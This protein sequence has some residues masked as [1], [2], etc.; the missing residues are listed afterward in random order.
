MKLTRIIELIVKYKTGTK[1]T[2]IKDSVLTYDF[3][4]VTPQRYEILEVSIDL[5]TLHFIVIRPETEEY[6]FGYYKDLKEH[7]KFRSVFINKCTAARNRVKA[8]KNQQKLIPNIIRSP[9]AKSMPTPKPHYFK[10]KPKR[11]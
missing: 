11:S 2:T 5:K 6:V 1:N 7:S 4:M 8:L 10:R 3:E 9:K